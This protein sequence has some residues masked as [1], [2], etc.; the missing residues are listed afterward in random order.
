MIPI[1]S[2]LTEKSIIFPTEKE[3]IQKIQVIERS[4]HMKKISFLNATNTNFLPSSFRDFYMDNET[5]KIYPWVKNIEQKHR[6]R[7]AKQISKKEDHEV[8]IPSKQINLSSC[9]QMLFP[10]VGTE[11]KV[12]NLSEYV[13]AQRIK[14]KSLR[15][16]AEDIILDVIQ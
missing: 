8:E 15:E 10:V 11:E 2:L 7:I 6:L 3:I 13:K 12:L 4:L 5:L 16:I 14:D 1:K 9:K